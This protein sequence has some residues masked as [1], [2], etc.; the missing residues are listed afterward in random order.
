MYTFRVYKLAYKPV[1]G[2]EKK[3]V[4]HD[5]QFVNN[6]TIWAI[7]DHVIFKTL[8]RIKECIQVLISNILE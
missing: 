1:K 7:K 4:T 5:I 6:S 2:D 3:I 8:K